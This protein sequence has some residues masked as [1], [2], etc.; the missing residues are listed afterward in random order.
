MKSRLHAGP[1]DNVYFLTLTGGIAL[2]FLAIW[3]VSRA[4]E[5]TPVV[6]IVA[7]AFVLVPEVLPWLYVATA[8]IWWDDQRIGYRWLFRSSHVAR[9]RAH[10]LL[11]G[12][13]RIAFADRE[14]RPLMIVGRFMTD[15]QLRD[16]ASQL[17]FRLTGIGRFLGPLEV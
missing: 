8:E 14:A 17:G 6:I 1:K 13:G 2:F 5:S 7:A 11:A 3:I 12:T 15:A 4:W 9:V 10:R 16:T